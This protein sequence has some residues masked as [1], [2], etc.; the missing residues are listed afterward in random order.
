M[1]DAFMCPAMR[2]ISYRD[3]MHKWPEEKQKFRK[4]G[5]VI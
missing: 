4:C 3:C 5:L 2:F 1:G